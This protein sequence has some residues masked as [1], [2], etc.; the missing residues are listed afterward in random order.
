[1]IKG[2]NFWAFPLK[3]D[4]SPMDPIEAMCMA[5]ELGYEAFEHTVEASGPV[6]LETTEEQAEEIRKEAEKIGLRLD[7]VASG[8]AWGTSPTDPDESVRNKAVE[9]TKKVLQVASWL[10]AETILYLP[11]MVSVCFVPDFTPQP[12]DKVDAWAKEGIKKILPTAEKLGVKIGVENVWNRYLL[13][14]LEMRDFID[15]F[16]SDMVG[17]YF[18]VGNVMLYGHPV[19]W[20][21]ILGKRIFAV[22]L[23]DFR[24]N[25]GNLDGFV[26]ILAGDVDYP[27]VMEAFR[28]IGYNK[29]F[30]AE[31]VPPMLG[32]VEKQIAAMKIVEKM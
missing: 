26:D 9:N 21:D 23:K 25:V 30:T 29:T 27:A 3:D 16:D 1:M 24:V 17:S 14:P 18:D 8:L 13:S 19:H 28:R 32:A 12:Y 15:S 4:G 22:H 6:S 20:I 7:T 31:W 10:G 5:K 2:I 11:G